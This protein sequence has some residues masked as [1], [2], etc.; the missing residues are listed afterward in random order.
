MVGIDITVS[1]PRQFHSPG[2][3]AL[4]SRLQTAEAVV[5]SVPSLRSDLN[6]LETVLYGFLF[7]M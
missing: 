7:Y 6:D 1:D 5:D 4:D 3:A 2:Q